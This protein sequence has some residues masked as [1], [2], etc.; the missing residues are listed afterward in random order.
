MNLFGLAKQPLTAEQ[1][2]IIGVVITAIISLVY[3]WLLQLC[4]E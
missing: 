3:A 1:I 2:A 4:A